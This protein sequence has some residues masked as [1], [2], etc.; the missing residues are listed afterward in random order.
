VVLSEPMVGTQWNSGSV[1][2]RLLLVQ[3][4]LRFGR[5]YVCEREVPREQKIELI[6]D[7]D[8]SSW[9]IYSCIGI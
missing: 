5:R 8:K 6:K 4:S 3:R 1:T 7:H 2:S 9:E